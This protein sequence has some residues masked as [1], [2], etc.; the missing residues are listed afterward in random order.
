MSFPFQGDINRYFTRKNDIAAYLGCRERC[1]S[2]LMI[3][4]SFCVVLRGEEAVN[5][6]LRNISNS[7]P[8]PEKK[9]TR[10]HYA[11]GDPI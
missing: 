3:R 10:A 8:N 6:R 7:L 1:V 9:D 2:C 5:V 11:R 4:S